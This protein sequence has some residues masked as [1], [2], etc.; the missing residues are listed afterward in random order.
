MAL[1]R[2]GLISAASGVRHGGGL[3]IGRAKF[4]FDPSV[5]CCVTTRILPALFLGNREMFVVPFV[6]VMFVS[7][8]T[9]FFLSILLVS[10]QD[11]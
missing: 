6:R 10:I 5:N 9:R 3:S 4:F 11:L 1:G 8:S 2:G 7:Y